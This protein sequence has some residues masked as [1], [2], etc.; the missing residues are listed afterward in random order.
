[1]G[2][3]TKYHEQLKLSA[4]AWSRLTFSGFQMVPASE[5]EPASALE[6]RTC[7]CGTTLA[8]ETTTVTVAIRGASVIVAV[9][10]RQLFLTAAEAAQLASIMATSLKAMA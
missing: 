4:A 7:T 5:D 1:M 8:I 3:T 9:G 10:A 2:H 6:C